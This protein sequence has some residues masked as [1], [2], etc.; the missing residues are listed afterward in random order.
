[1][2][3]RNQVSVSWRSETAEAKSWVFINGRF[4]LGPFYGDAAE[5]SL[6]VTVPT[7]TTFLI[8]VHDF[9]DD[10]IPSPI[11]IPPKIQP[12]IGWNH[13]LNAA[14][15]RVYHT[16][17]DTGQIESLL[18]ELPPQG[19]RMEIL[20]P[21]KLEGR[22]GCWHSFRIVAVDQYG[23][24]SQSEVVPHQAMDFPK[25]PNLAISR[26]TFS[27]LLTFRLQTSGLGLQRLD[28]ANNLT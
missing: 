16:I 26:D 27:N 18:V 20:C 9:E 23:N 12:T 28:F 13:A 8:E 15:Y 24:E 7:E 2:L 1:M 3:T 5:R 11:A 25:P 10:T 22:G 17:F 19:E 6:F 21:V 14:K 4:V